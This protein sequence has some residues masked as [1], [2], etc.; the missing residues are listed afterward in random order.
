MEQAKRIGEEKVM[1]QKKIVGCVMLEADS[2]E[3]PKSWGFQVLRGLAM[4]QQELTPRKRMRLDLQSPAGQGSLKIFASLVGPS[5]SSC[6]AGPKRIVR[7]WSS[8]CICVQ[9]DQMIVLQ[10]IR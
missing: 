7:L 5:L 6:C 8:G 1:T 2:L 9:N 3:V 4:Q 10:H